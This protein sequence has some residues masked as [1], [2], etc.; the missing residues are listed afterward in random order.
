MAPLIPSLRN[1]V[2]N[3]RHIAAWLVL[4]ALIFAL[5]GCASLPSAY[6]EPAPLTAAQRTELNTRIFDTAGR[7]V[8][9]KYFDPDFRGRDWAALLRQYRPAAV[10]AADDAE[11]Y[12]VLN[13]L[14]R[15][16]KESHLTALAPQRAY[17]VRT[18]HCM[19]VGMG[20]DRV[21]GRHVVTELIPGGPAAQAGVQPGWIV[22]ACEGHPLANEFPRSPATGR[23]VT[24]SFLDLANAPRDITFQPQLLKVEQMVSRDLPGGCRYLRF[25]RFGSDALHWLSAELKAHRD[26]PG[27]VLDLREN[28][29]GYVV[30]FR[31][32]VGEF[33]DHR[34]ATGEFVRRDGKVQEGHNL[35]LFSA[36]YPGKVVIL[37]SESTGSAAEIF[38][39]VLQYNGRATV[40]GR[41]TAG[42]VIVSHNYR[43]PGGGT[44]Q[45][46][47]QDY[48]GLDGR[49]LEGRGVL[50]NITVAPAALA[51]LREGRDL[52]LE[53]A[54]ASLETTGVGNLAAG[55]H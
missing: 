15:E 53:T 27:V 39:H 41:R 20:W 54:L 4:L 30:A 34:V 8:R 3:S 43:L 13:H 36:R 52:D 33:F 38:T 19:A 12:R 6:V 23:P 16:L 37:T 48:R 45:V 22:T 29:G 46:P 42:A 9:E 35:S 51:D 10:A 40:I 44:L 50:P 26:A 1:Q 11:L 14:F 18:A 5:T 32:A 47:V 24:Y 28:P 25:D 55:G 2:A 31:L 49:R 7:I 17:E 21:E